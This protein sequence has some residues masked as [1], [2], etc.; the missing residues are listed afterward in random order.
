MDKWR[1]VH[2]RRNITMKASTFHK[3]VP[4]TKEEY[5][6]FKELQRIRAKHTQEE[7]MRPSAILPL[8]SA[9]RAKEEVLFTPTNKPELQQQ[10]FNHLSSLVNQLKNKVLEQKNPPPPPQIIEQP[11]PA[12]QP[13]PMDDGPQPG[14]SPYSEAVNA[15]IPPRARKLF[16][17]LGNEVW[18]EKSELTIDGKPIPNSNIVDLL[19]YATGRWNTKYNG[20]EPTGATEF[21]HLIKEKNATS[22]LGKQPLKQMN[23]PIRGYAI[24]TPKKTRKRTAE[25]VDAGMKMLSAPAKQLQSVFGPR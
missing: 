13:V 23:S 20:R 25:D 8:E 19:D 11:L 15:F 1:K 6:E 21:L 22:L 24:A 4:I 7:L 2:K 16:S 5:H 14:P 9:Q 10:Q 12:A 18:N 17:T 3:Y